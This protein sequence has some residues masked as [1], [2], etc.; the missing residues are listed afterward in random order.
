MMFRYILKLSILI[1]F[2]TTEA[3]AEIRLQ[4]E[5]KVICS[6]AT[7]HNSG[8]N[9]VIQPGDERL[10][11]SDDEINSLLTRIRNDLP[12][13]CGNRPLPSGNIDVSAAHSRVQT[14]FQ[15]Y[16]DSQKGNWTVKYN[17]IRRDILEAERR[18]AEQGLAA[19]K[20]QQAAQQR[21]TIRSKFISEFGIQGWTNQAVLTANPFPFKD[22]VIG[23]RADFQ[24]MVSANEAFFGSGN[25]PISVSNVPSTEFTIPGQQLVLAMRIIGIKPVQMPILGQVNTATGS[26]VGVYRCQVANCL[27]FF[28]R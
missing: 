27:D 8:V 3:S 18:Q 9:I 10:F 28:D 14:E 25:I 13:N 7:Y 12:Q 4:Y 2:I 24:Q 15:A 19:A 17:N 22:K 21:Q 1:F 23:I 26:Y 20:A 6:D 16:F 5:E 11:V